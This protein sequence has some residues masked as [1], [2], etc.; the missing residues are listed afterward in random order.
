MSD[1]EET[2]L[3][4]VVKFSTHEFKTEFENLLEVIK[5]SAET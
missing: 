2:V 4:A 1:H 5:T 3:G